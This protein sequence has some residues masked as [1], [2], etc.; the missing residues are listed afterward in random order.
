[1]TY[2]INAGT[3]L[4]LGYDDRFRDGMKID[5]VLFPFMAYQRTNRAF[6]G[7]VSYLFRY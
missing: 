4:F 6:F 1:M 3:V 5:S 7:K 2:R